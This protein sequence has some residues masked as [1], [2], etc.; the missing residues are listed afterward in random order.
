MGKVRLA[1]AN[2]LQ[3]SGKQLIDDDMRFLWITDFPLF[4][5]DENG[6]LQSA[7]HP[8]TAPHPED[9]HL[10]ESS[11]EKVS[12]ISIFF[13]FKCFYLI[14]IFGNLY[15]VKNSIFSDSKI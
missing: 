5:K 11:P 9:L 6:V 4:E 8:F 12:G 10:L 7:H 15:Y 1:Y 3:D 2:N 14:F 13:K